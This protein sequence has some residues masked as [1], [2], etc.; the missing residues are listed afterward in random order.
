MN[1][2]N[3]LLGFLFSVIS[4]WESFVWMLEGVTCN[5]DCFMLGL[6]LFHAYFTYWCWYCIC[7]YLNIFVISLELLKIENSLLNWWEFELDY[8]AINPNCALT[9]INLSDLII[10]SYLS[11]CRELR[12]ELQNLESSSLNLLQDKRFIKF[13]YMR[14]YSN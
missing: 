14:S 2:C 11:N 12:I 1:F 4:Q 9:F 3:K 13:W 10:M 6:C 5:Y 7:D 8:W